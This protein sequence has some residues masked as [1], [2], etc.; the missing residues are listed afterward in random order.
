[1]VAICETFNVYMSLCFVKI[2]HNNIQY[3][4]K[5][6]PFIY[7]SHPNIVFFKSHSD[8]FQ[9]NLVFQIN[10]SDL[11]ENILIKIASISIIKKYPTKIA[12]TFPLFI[13][14]MKY[15]TRSGWLR[16]TCSCLVIGHVC[17]KAVLRNF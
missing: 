6:L 12:L 14:D 5:T 2:E 4:L 13:K 17:L 7:L 3:F 15:K 8:Y 9:K 1:M 10:I 11:L 16:D